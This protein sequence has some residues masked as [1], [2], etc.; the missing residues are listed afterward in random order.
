[1]GGVGQMGERPQEGGELV[2]TSVSG[3]LDSGSTTSA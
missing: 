2:C 1:M 3:R